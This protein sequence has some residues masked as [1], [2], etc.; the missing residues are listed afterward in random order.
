[1]KKEMVSK[2][3]VGSSSHYLHQRLCQMYLNRQ[4][5]QHHLK[6]ARTLNIY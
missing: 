5:N 1:M 2:C 6:K 3:P 4:P